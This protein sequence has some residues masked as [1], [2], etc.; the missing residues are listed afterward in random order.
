MT[1]LTFYDG[2]NEI[3]GNEISLED[4][5]T[6]IFINF[7]IQVD[8]TNN[9]FV[10][11][12]SRTL[13]G[14]GDIFEFDLLDIKGI[15][16]AEYSEHMDYGDRHMDTSI[17]GTLFSHTHLDH[18]A[19]IHYLRPEIPIYSSEATKLIMS[20]LDD[21]GDIE[22]IIYKQNFKISENSTDKKSR[23]VSPNREIP[24]N[25][26]VIDSTHILKIDSI[27]VESFSIVHS[28]SNVLGFLIH[29]SEGNIGYTTDIRFHVIQEEQSQD[30]VEKC[31]SE[32]LDYLLC[33]RTRID[34]YESYT[35]FDVEECVSNTIKE[36]ENLVV[37]T[38]PTR[39]LDRFLSFYNT[40]QDTDRNIVIY[41]KQAYLLKLFQESEEWK[42][43]F[44]SPKNDSTIKI[45]L[46]RKSWGLGRD[47]DKWTE[48]II[49]VDYYSW[50]RNFLDYPNCIDYT[51]VHKKQKE[52]IFYCP[53]YKLQDLIDVQP[54]N[55]TYIHSSTEP[56]DDEMEL[57][58]ERVKNWLTHFGLLSSDRKWHYFHVSG[59]DSADQI[60]KII[61]ETDSK[62]LIPIH[63]QHE[64]IFDKLHKNVRKV[65]LGETI[66]LNLA[67]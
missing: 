10:G 46:S 3:G 54:E 15:Y 6:R 25:I 18:C 53:D 29:T 26:K 43:R 11:F 58:Q 20:C 28:L 14:M 45:F 32:N 9:Y 33:Q 23:L 41:T 21:T 65:N 44:P 34:N 49:H 64:D 24:R 40:V 1:S 31:K 39:D 42:N 17:D 66:P 57:D 60:K 19:Y 27:H 47:S 62:T 7:G 13:N 56:F 4:K 50:E 22:Y 36:A 2:I 48:N 5:R 63:T 61:N 30:F 59:H 52:Y 37:C 67:T 12:L 55:S 51:D 38:C 8:K 16:R 35:E